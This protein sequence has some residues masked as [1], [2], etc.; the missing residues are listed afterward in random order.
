ML[1]VDSMPNAFTTS[2]RCAGAPM[3]I[4]WDE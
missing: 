1:I 2:N 4:T 3:T